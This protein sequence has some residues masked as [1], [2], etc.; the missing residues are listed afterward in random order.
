MNIRPTALLVRA[1]AVAFLLGFVLLFY[2]E[3]KSWLK[4]L[5][6]VLSI[7]VCA[8]FI[9]SIPRPDCTASRTAAHTVPLGVPTTIN[10]QLRNL[11]SQT[12]NLEVFDHYPSIH[13]L[14]GLPRQIQ[15]EAGQKTDFDYKITP[16]E[17]GKF[18]FAKIE[19]R[20]TSLLGFW[21]RYF[22]IEEKH[23]IK[24]YPNYSEVIKFGTLA[25]EQRLS[26]MGIMRKRHRGTG[27]EFHQLREFRQGDRLGSI[28]WKASSRIQ[29]LIAREYQIERDQQIF[30][31]LDC[32]RRMRSMDG[33]LSHFDHA[34]N[35]MLLLSYVA[36]RQGDAV[37]MMTFAGPERWL[38]PK[39]SSSNVNRFL[40]SLYDL[41]PSTEAADFIK[42]AEK[43]KTLLKKRAMVIVLSNLR[44]EDDEDLHSALKLLRQQ[45][46]V[47]F[48]ALKEE[49]FEKELEAPVENFKDALRYG[50]L[51]DYL[52]HRDTVFEK[53]HAD[54]I[55]ALDV[56]P[57][58]LHI[59]LVNR[60]LE[61]KSSC[62]L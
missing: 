19:L 10:L 11:G 14:D 30:F 48:A 3:L 33:E 47:V 61:I 39:K 50:S 51:N 29:K 58:N 57:Q 56:K 62:K 12:R 31:L 15:L 13:K 49:V 44:D 59:E 32:G 9:Q 38:P 6:S 5:C 34:L 42:A 28:D 24:V 46:L 16:V 8:D 7:V 2:P 43:T 25:A 4:G 40:N 27:T 45:H 35:A 17:R 36:S 26:Q 18:S 22:T 41:Q 21:H 1:L 53:M 37:G 55:I 52:M 20:S 60:Y 23:E 54:K